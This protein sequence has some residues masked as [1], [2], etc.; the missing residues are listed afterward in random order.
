MKQKFNIKKFRDEIKPDLNSISGGDVSLGFYRN[1]LSMNWDFDVYLP[2]FKVNLQRDFVWTL[3]QKQELILSIFKDIKIPP[4]TVLINDSIQGNNKYLV[5]DGK[6]RIKTIIDYFNNC[7]PVM[8]HGQKIAFDDLDT[9]SNHF[10]SYRHLVGYVMYSSDGYDPVSDVGKIK[11]FNY[12]NFA[13]TPQDKA[14]SQKLLSFINN[15]PTN[16]QQPNT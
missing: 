3:K 2:T 12:I 6:Q 10:F 1:L 9:E 16:I 8:I 15:E 13:G 11:W 14:H 7:F 4:V 5:I